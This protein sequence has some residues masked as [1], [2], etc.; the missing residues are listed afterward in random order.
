MVVFIKVFAIVYLGFVAG[1]KPEPT[2]SELI[3]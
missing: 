1:G 2:L 3:S